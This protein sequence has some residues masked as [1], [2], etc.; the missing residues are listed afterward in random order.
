MATSARDDQGVLSGEHPLVYRYE[1]EFDPPIQTRK[2]LSDG[3]KEMHKLEFFG[4]SEDAFYM[5]NVAFS[6][7]LETGQ[8]KRLEAVILTADSVAT[9]QDRNPNELA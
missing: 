4:S 8:L 9:W 3:T 5:L 7:M 2:R 6:R 1:L